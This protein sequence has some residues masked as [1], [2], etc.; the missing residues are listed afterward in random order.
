MDTQGGVRYTMLMAN[1]KRALVRLPWKLVVVLGAA[2][3]MRPV[4]KIFGDVFGYEVSA[5]GAISLT[6]VIAAAWVYAVVSLKVERPVAVLAA[7]GATYAV[8]S[9][10]LAV[11]LQVAVP[12]LGSQQ[13]NIAVL[14][15][16]G[17]FGSLVGNIIYGAA[18]GVIAE[19]IQ[20]RTSGSQKRK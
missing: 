1:F 7:S 8:L 13:V 15:T 19:I 3:L 9:V 4:V 6:L 11:V 12:G 14:L 16:A 18:L 5:A 2:A 17:L 10:L 20:K